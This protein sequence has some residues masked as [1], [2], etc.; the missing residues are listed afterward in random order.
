MKLAKVVNKKLII[1]AKQTLGNSVEVQQDQTLI[2]NED[3]TEEH[4]FENSHGREI[5]TEAGLKI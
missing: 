2:W 3:V 1:I 4:L 5:G